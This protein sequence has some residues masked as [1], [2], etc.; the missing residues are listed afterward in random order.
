MKSLMSA[1]LVLIGFAC[2]TLLGNTMPAAQESLG[3]RVQQILGVEGNG[4]LLPALAEALGGVA[5]DPERSDAALAGLVG[6]LN[7]G[8]KP[9]SLDRLLIERTPLADPM[10]FQQVPEW[11][12]GVYGDR[13]QLAALLWHRSLTHHQANRADEARAYA[14]A[15]LLLAGE[16]EF[17]LTVG[18]LHPMLLD[19]IRLRDVAGL[20][21]RQIEAL[22]QLSLEIRKRDHAFSFGPLSMAESIREGLEATDG[23]LPAK[24]ME[25][26]IQAL[27]AARETAS[28]SLTRQFD[29]IT[30]VRT[31]LMLARTRGT[32]QQVETVAAFINEWRREADGPVKRWLEEAEK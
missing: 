14:R 20:D 6:V 3:V 21:E 27:R 12:Y 32:P 18:V 30:E 4:E 22:N 8:V 15:A 24:K 1:T 5:K 2:V 19:P 26:A 28:G 16:Q 13:A 7:E 31:L 17:W 11:P 25:E 23:E 29:L 9:G 10:K